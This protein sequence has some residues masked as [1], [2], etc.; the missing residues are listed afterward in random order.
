MVNGDKE[1]RGK[2]GEEREDEVG[3]RR[4]RIGRG[5]EGG[6]EGRKGRGDT[7]ANQCRPRINISSEDP[8]SGEEG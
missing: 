4:G 5:T 7:K 8:P 1:G 2:G 6:R 3:R